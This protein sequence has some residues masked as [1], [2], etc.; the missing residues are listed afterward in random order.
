MSATANIKIAK[1]FMS[2]RSQAVRIPLEYKFDEDELFVNRIGKTLMLTPKSALKESLIEGA[3]LIPE[4]FMEE[5][6]PEEIPVKREE[7]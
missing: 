5:G 2:G 1:V 7:L 4:D 3:A 6:L